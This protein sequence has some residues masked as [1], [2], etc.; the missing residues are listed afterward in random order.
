MHDGTFQNRYEVKGSPLELTLS[1]E[2]CFSKKEVDVK[3][4]NFEEQSDVWLLRGGKGALKR[5]TAP[6]LAEVAALPAK[7]TP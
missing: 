7:Q 6:A 4:S 3:K 5:F 1:W 2:S